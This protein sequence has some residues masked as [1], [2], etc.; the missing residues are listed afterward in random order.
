MSHPLPIANGEVPAK[1]PEGAHA[2]A[3]NIDPEVLIK[4]FH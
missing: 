1:E 3:L 2:A 4:A